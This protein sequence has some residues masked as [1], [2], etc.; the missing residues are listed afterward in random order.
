MPH[1][2]NNLTPRCIRCGYDLR[3]LND[4]GH[5]PECGAG[6]QRSQQASAADVQFWRKLMTAG[7]TLLAIGWFSSSAVLVGQAFTVAD[8]FNFIGSPVPSIVAGGC[9]HVVILPVILIAMFLLGWQA[10]AGMIA[11]DNGWARAAQAASFGCVVMGFVAFAGT[12]TFSFV[13]PLAALAAI[14]CLQLGQW[15]AVLRAARI[16]DAFDYTGS[17]TTLRWIAYVRPVLIVLIWGAIFT[18]WG[19]ISTTLAVP[20]W[21]MLLARGVLLTLATLN[22]IGVITLLLL[23]RRTDWLRVADTPSAVP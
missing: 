3:H 4:V 15:F 1:H 14:A 12:N 19:P 6:I 5:C 7:V 16:A 10:P 11:G 23:L 21:E 17:A 18:N 22:I 13:S 8:D 9:W 2:A 20:L